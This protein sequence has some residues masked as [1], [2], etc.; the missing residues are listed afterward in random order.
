MAPGSS[1][2]S[3]CGAYFKIY[4]KIPITEKIKLFP[5]KE[6]G[7]I[8]KKIV[9]KGMIIKDK[10]FDE[11]FRIKCESEDVAINIFTPTTREYFMIFYD[12][13]ETAIPFTPKDS[14]NQNQRFSFIV[15]YENYIEAGLNYFPDCNTIIELFDILIDA[16]IT[17]EKECWFRGEGK[18]S[19][20]N[21]GYDLEFID[22]YES[23]YC[24][25]CEEYVE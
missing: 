2:G 13:A 22:E 21:C 17:I 20:P 4:H 24:Y 7:R 1:V 23:W 16:T 8:G 25:S 14:Y 3:P 18:W 15:I 12:I 19:C 6:L 9:P 5:N 10:Q 11:I